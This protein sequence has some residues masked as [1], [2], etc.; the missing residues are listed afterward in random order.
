MFCLTFC[1]YISLTV[2]FIKCYGNIWD[3]FVLHLHRRDLSVGRGSTATITGG[4]LPKIHTVE[5]WDG[6]DGVVSTFLLLLL[7]FFEV[8]Y[9]NV[10]MLYLFTV[11]K[12]NTNTVENF[13]KHICRSI[14]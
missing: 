3:V 11:K 10:A 9:C 12:Q 6:K 5:A 2:D 8:N 4:A 13:Q 1:S 14:D 7:L